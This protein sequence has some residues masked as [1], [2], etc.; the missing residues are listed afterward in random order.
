[1]V[2]EI[3]GEFADAV[4][5]GDHQRASD[6]ADEFIDVL[7]RQTEID[8]ARATAANSLLGDSVLSQETSSLAGDVVEE[9]SQARQLRAQVGT[10]IQALGSGQLKTEEVG[11]IVEQLASVQSNINESYRQLRETQEITELDSILVSSG[12]DILEVQT[13]S[14]EVEDDSS[15]ESEQRSGAT[16]NGDSESKGGNGNRGGNGRGNGNRGGNSNDTAKSENSGGPHS[17]IAVEPTAEIIVRN[18]GGVAAERVGLSV[19]T[20]LTNVSVDPARLEEIEGGSEE[21]VKIS[22][23]QENKPGRYELALN[24]G[25]GSTGTTESFPVVIV[26]KERYIG[27]AI[28]S[29]ESLERTF[30]ELNANSNRSLR[31]FLKTIR[32]SIRRLRDVKKQLANETIST[33]RANQEI[34]P[35]TQQ[36]EGLAKQVSSLRFL[37]GG[38]RAKLKSEIKAVVE[39]LDRSLEAGT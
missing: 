17:G 11:A 6:L 1:M 12:P 30:E 34:F 4:R 13:A 16:G 19:D 2:E 7:S 8:V 22:V 20:Q 21:T 39:T 27:D 18:V 23:G 25:G 26:D 32:R 37:S 38:K 14:E 15:D 9:I 36:L 10:S 33:K 24:I 5:S 29:L 3:Y 31:S 28:Q 35:V